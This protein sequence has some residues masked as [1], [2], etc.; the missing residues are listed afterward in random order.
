MDSAQTA[1]RHDGANAGGG[2]TSA[3]EP[4]AGND[5]SLDNEVATAF[6]AERRPY[7]PRSEPVSPPRDDADIMDTSNDSTTNRRHEMGHEQAGRRHDSG[8]VHASS[9]SRNG[10]VASRAA[11][12]SSDFQQQQP[13]FHHQSPFLGYHS[14]DGGIYSLRMPFFGP[15]DPYMSGWYPNSPRQRNSVAPPSSGEDRDYSARGR[16]LGRDRI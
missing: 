5:S 2:E 1:L 16:D 10:D 3:N 7:T 8:S 9:A 4:L 14:T 12:T 11:A 6:S 15:S 13:Y